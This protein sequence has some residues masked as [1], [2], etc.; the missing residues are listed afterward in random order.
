[1]WDAFDLVKSDKDNEHSDR[2]SKNSVMKEEG[3]KLLQFGG[4]NS[5]EILN[6]K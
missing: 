3:R 4:R 1:M 2:L 6:I 5:V